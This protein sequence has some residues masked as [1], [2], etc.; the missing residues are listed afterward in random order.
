MSPEQLKY[1]AYHSPAQKA[2]RT[3]SAQQCTEAAIREAHHLYFAG[4]K[5]GAEQRLLSSGFQTE[6]I[7]FFLH[8]WGSDL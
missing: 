8:T 2:D 3:R 5:L 1:E 4:D 6:G 7:S